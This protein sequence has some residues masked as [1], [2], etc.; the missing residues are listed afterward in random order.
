VTR[1]FMRLSVR[2]LERVARS[3][4]LVVTG[5]AVHVESIVLVMHS[6]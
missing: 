1:P 6:V 5:D 2:A 3:F 4:L